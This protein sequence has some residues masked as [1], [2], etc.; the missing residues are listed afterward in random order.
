MIA[1][2]IYTY[3]LDALEEVITW[4]REIGSRVPRWMELMV[5]THRD[6]GEPEVVVTGPVLAPSEAEAREA[7]ALLESCPASGRSPKPCRRRPRTCSG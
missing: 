7:L 2:G 6:E 5:F 4:A 1:S 3:P